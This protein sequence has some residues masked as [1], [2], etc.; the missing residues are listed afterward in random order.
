MIKK[1]SRFRLEYSLPI[2]SPTDAN[3]VSAYI[4]VEGI[5]SDFGVNGPCG[6]TV[7]LTRL[8]LHL[9]RRGSHMLLLLGFRLLESRLLGS[10]LLGFKILLQFK[11]CPHSGLM[12]LT[13]TS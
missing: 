12:D 9:L 5:F 8:I 1:I 7:G 4:A 2:F 10:R 6:T 11:L 3:S 13:M